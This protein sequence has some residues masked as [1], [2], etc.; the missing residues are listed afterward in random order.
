M[1]S[2]TPRCK[3]DGKELERR[4][5]ES[6]L[7]DNLIGTIMARFGDY[8]CNREAYK[9]GFCVFHSE[10]KPDNFEELFWE[11]FRRMEREEEVID[12]TGAIFPSFR[13]SSE[14]E[15]LETSKPLV[16]VGAKFKE[17]VFDGAKLRL[18]YLHGAE[19]EVGSFRKVEVGGAIFLGAKFKSGFFTGARIGGAFFSDS[20]FYLA[21][22]VG[23]E[24]GDAF[25]TRVKADT[26]M[27]SAV[28]IKKADFKGAELGSADFD[29][30]EFGEADFKEAKLVR[31]NFRRSVFKEVARLEFECEEVAD[32]SS[33]VFELA[34][35]IRPRLKGVLVLHMTIFKEPRKVVIE[36][37]LKSTSLLQTDL[38]DVILIPLGKG[39]I[40]DERL[41]WEKMGKA[42]SKGSRRSS[43]RLGLEMEAY[44]LISDY[45]DEELVIAEYRTIRRSLELNRMYNEASQFFLRE[46][47]LIRRRLS[48][49]S[50]REG[51][52]KLAHYVYDLVALYGESI[53]RPLT[54]SAGLILLFSL[55]LGVMGGFN[56]SG[57]EGLKT[58]LS[59]V[60]E[61]LAV[62]LQVS[63][64]RDFGM[65]LPPGKLTLME[66]LIKGSSLMM[67]GSIFIA[68]R[69]RLER[70]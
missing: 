35:L 65:N 54:F 11:E 33:S 70:K 19:F 20:E 5:R 23:A 55:I 60:G 8:K 67:I 59:L 51:A 29:Y 49:W 13:F 27:F 32:F 62:F 40:L 31:A 14:D 64:L 10:E 18:I 39:V 12:F 58:Y 53:A 1:L 50:F 61:T 69:R 6:G 7:N 42:R 66:V 52:E 56:L 17:A 68:L 3:F 34:A 37:P 47:R 57:W 25:F 45:L 41:L 48:W 16:F 43:H 2:S 63:S 21:F 28:K 26:A 38:K 9:D 15:P 4:L 46:M 22:F 36:V 24:M 30:A 44:R